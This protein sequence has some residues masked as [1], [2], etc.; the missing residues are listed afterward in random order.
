MKIN[1]DFKGIEKRFQTT[2]E[3]EL[4]KSIQT[5]RDTLK[6]HYERFYFKN[7]KELNEY[8][9]DHLLFESLNQLIKSY[10]HNVSESLNKKDYDLMLWN[11]T[12]LLTSIFAHVHWINN[13]YSVYSIDGV[14]QDGSSYSWTEKREYFISENDNYIKLDYRVIESTIPL[15]NGKRNTR[16]FVTND[17]MII[18]VNYVVFDKCT[19]KELSENISLM[20]VLK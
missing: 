8:M 14:A 12:F 10:N 17:K 9:R 13:L 15:L 2:F 16:F 5:I 7:E 4:S 20:E 11:Q 3:K 19:T 1:I 18:L 6:W